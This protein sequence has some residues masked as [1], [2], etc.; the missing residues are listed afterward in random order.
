[1]ARA[2][3]ARVAIVC[4]RGLALVLVAAVPLLAQPAQ[5]TKVT[6]D[7]MDVRQS[8]Q[9]IQLLLLAR[10]D[11]ALTGALQ[12][13]PFARGWL[14][15]SLETATGAVRI[16][17]VE[18]VTVDSTLPVL[19][20]KLAPVDPAWLDTASHTVSVTFLRST[21]LARAVSAPSAAAPSAVSPGAF[22]AAATAQAADVYFS[23]KITG[24]PGAKPEVLV[25]GQAPERLGAAEQQR[26]LGLPRRNGGRRRD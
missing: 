1:M 15:Q 8:S 25:R 23:G 2:V 6:I 17:E 16:L 5:T 7:Q 4:A 14:V 13:A 11:P 12:R 20:L 21:N 19:T 18:S 3:T 26:A 24:T 10:P 22:K 9:T